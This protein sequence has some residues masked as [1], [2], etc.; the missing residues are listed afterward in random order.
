MANT[1]TFCCPTSSLVSSL[2][3]MS[4]SWSATSAALATHGNNQSTL[5]LPSRQLGPTGAPDWLLTEA[6]HTCRHLDGVN[7][8][9]IPEVCSRP[10]GGQRVRVNQTGRKRA[11]GKKRKIF[12]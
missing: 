8:G 10:I 9:A 6:E 7:V 5:F 1:C 3:V 11:K 2:L 4:A 12:R